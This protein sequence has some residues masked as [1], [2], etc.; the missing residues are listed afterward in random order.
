MTETF[1]VYNPE[2]RKTQDI[3]LIF[4]LEK[5]ARTKFMKNFIIALIQTKR[6]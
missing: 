2:E 6:K 1:F 5:R 4:N 3:D